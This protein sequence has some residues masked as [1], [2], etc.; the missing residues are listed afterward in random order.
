MLAYHVDPSD[1]GFSKWLSMNEVNIDP[2][3]QHV[4]LLEADGRN[5][6]FSSTDEFYSDRRSIKGIFFPYNDID[7]LDQEN[8]SGLVFWNG[9]RSDCSLTSIRREGNG[10]RFTF[11]SNDNTALPPSAVNITKE[12]FADAAII[13]F[14]SSYPYEGEATV[15]WRRAGGEFN[16]VMLKPYSP[17]KYA[18][19]LENLESSG[20]TY[21]ASISF[22][23]NGI[24]SESRSVSVMTKRMPSV[25]WPYIYLGSMERNSDGSFKSG[26]KCP[27]RV[28]GATGAAEVRWEFNGKSITHEG[29]GYFRFRSGG[30]L[31]ATVFWEDGSTDKIIKEI[32]ISSE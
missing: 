7:A 24:E 25:D 15:S 30:K 31:Q 21:E 1:G 18:I 27:L 4:D 3:H 11:L 23:L 12:A 19:V 17:G 8:R 9:S 16:T 26:A 14:E 2:A 10:I 22:T 5:D 6:S 28:Y 32:R 13:G 20:K 29:D